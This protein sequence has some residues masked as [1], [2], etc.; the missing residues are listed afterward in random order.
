MASVPYAVGDII[1]CL[2]RY[3]NDQ[4]YVQVRTVK[5]KRLMVAVL[6]MTT[7][8]RGLANPY[9]STIVYQVTQ[10]IVAPGGHWARMSKEHGWSFMTDAGDVTSRMLLCTVMPVPLPNPLCFEKTIYY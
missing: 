10:P 3:G 6:D 7:A 5:G 1:E 2:S 8:S 9:Q 4:C